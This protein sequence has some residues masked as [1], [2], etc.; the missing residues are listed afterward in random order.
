MAGC[1][2]IAWTMCFLNCVEIEVAGLC[3]GEVDEGLSRSHDG[4]LHQYEPLELNAH[5]IEVENQPLSVGCCIS[6]L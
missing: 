1:D 5:P 6:L 4:F 3:I 2:F